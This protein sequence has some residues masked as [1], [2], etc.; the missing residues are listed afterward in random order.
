MQE[1]PGTLARVRNAAHNALDAVQ[2]RTGLRVV[3]APSA[4]EPERSHPDIADPSFYALCRRCAPYTMTSVER[5]FALYQAVGHVHRAGVEGD[6]V[7]CGVWRGGSSM[8]AALR[9]LELDDAERTLWLFDTFD[10]M[11]EPGAHD[12]DPTGASMAAEWSRHRD[13]PDDAVFAYAGLDEVRRAMAS[14]GYPESRLQFV[15]GQVEQT[16]PASAP[17]RIA[18]LRLDTDWYESTR[19]ELEHLYPRLVAGGVLIIDDYGHWQG[20]RRAVDEWL[21]TTG[22]P[23]LLSRIDET[24]RIAVKPA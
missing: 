17:E 7:E 2:A 22:A 6:V 16:I 13:R 23:L 21:A 1:T 19:H 4:H 5:M 10:G 18:V 20:A 24:G 8:L 11:P 3:R 12:V 15:R 14:T 9:L